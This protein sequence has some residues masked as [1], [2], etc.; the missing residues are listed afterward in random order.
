[1]GD[2][3][4]TEIYGVDSRSHERSSMDSADERAANLKENVPINL[5]SL[6]KVLQAIKEY[7]FSLSVLTP[8]SAIMTAN[9]THS[10]LFSQKNG[11]LAIKKLCV[12]DQIIFARP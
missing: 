5:K 2:Q 1:M 12:F 6:R 3:R 7:N 9:V 10:N 11:A 4:T 8:Q